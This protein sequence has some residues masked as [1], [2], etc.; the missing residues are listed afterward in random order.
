VGRG[1]SDLEQTMLRSQND[2]VHAK[3]RVSARVVGQRARSAR[4][5][6][7]CQLLSRARWAPFVVHQRVL[8]RRRIV[9]GTNHRVLY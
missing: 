8:T 2:C 3:T 5:W 1:G 6:Q 7:Y 9:V 4:C